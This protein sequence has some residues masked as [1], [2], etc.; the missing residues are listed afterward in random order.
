MIVTG[1]PSSGRQRVGEA[2]VRLRPGTLSE[3]VTLHSDEYTP[4][5][6]I[7]RLFGKDDGD[8]GSALLGRENAT[9]V[10]RGLE[11]VQ[12]RVRNAW[13]SIS[14]KAPF[15]RPARVGAAPASPA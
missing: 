11:H 13:R 1:E 12:L 8:I 4:A 6:I 9:I 10:L 2:I 14:N 3:V 5:Q 15:A 7:G